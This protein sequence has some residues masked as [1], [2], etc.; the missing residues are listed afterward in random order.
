MRVAIA[1]ACLV[2]SIAAARAQEV[3]T[4][5]AGQPIRLNFASTVNPDCSSAGATTVRVTQPP[6]HGRLDIAK[7]MDFPSF[8]RKTVRTHCNKR[9]VAGTLIRYVSQRGFV[10]TDSA[11]VEI[12]FA[13]GVHATRSYRINVR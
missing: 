12:F 3:R 4:G 2:L 8:A 11:A 13:N 10:G 9:R 5:L 1:L 7:A 6:Q